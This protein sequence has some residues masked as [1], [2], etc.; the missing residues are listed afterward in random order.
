VA[1]AAAADPGRIA[2]L[3]ASLRGRMAASP[4]M[5]EARFARDMETAYRDM[6]HAWCARP[7]S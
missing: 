5:D 7:M 2:S 1:A 6:W 3:R 4:L